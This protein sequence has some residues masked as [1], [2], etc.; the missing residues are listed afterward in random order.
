MELTLEQLK[1]ISMSKNELILQQVLPALNETLSKYEINTPIRV[2]HFLAQV[3]HESAAF[4]YFEEIA[5]GKAYEGRKD[6]GN[7]NEGDGMKY[8]GRGIIQITGRANYTLI[9]QDLG[10]DFVNNPKTLADKK[11]AVVSAGWFWNKRKLNAIA[12]TDDFIK[13]TKR[14]NGGTNGLEDR[15]RYLLKAKTVLGI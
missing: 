13:V 7:I 6:L 11:W 14:V 9:S 1:A 3:L 10:V 2:A 12:D 4:R 15:R 5:S 8:K